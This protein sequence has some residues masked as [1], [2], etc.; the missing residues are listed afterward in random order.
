MFKHLYSFLFQAKQARPVSGRQSS[1][2]VKNTNVPSRGGSG[3]LSA[4]RGG[5]GVR[6]LASKEEEYK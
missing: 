2:S 3:N 1:Q 4:S 5:S 6:D